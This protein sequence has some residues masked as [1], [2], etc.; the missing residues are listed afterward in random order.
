MFVY[1]CSVSFNSEA[2]VANAED[3]HAAHVVRTLNTA[4]ISLL[5]SR[6]PRVGKVVCLPPMTGLITIQ[7]TNAI[8]D[9]HSTRVQCPNGTPVTSHS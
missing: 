5:L 6:M 8:L 3:S 2:Q 1:L 4:L 7:N 9:Y